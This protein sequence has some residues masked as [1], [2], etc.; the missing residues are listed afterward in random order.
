MEVF[1]SVVVAGAIVVVFV[2]VV[3]F[4][5]DDE[6]AVEAKGEEVVIVMDADTMRTVRCQLNLDE[7]QLV[8]NVRKY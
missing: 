7:E 3:L 8:Q 2:L 5:F 6:G 1:A 4:W